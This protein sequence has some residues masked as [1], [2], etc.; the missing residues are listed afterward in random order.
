LR[1]RTQAIG[2]REQPTHLRQQILPHGRQFD[3]ALRAHEQ[4]HA[5][6]VLQR[7]DGLRQRRLR[8]GEPRCGSAEVHFLGNRHKITQQSEFDVPRFH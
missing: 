3:R 6:H 1:E 4:R 8:H 7:P 2:T 5:K